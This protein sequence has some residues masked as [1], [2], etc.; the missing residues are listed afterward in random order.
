M[1][2]LNVKPAPGKVVPNPENGMKPIRPEGQMVNQTSY[3]TRRLRDGSL[4][5]V[6]EPTPVPKPPVAA[7][8]KE[9]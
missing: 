9:C 1:N 3:I 5:Q 8:K 6:L 2:R 4:I 7:D